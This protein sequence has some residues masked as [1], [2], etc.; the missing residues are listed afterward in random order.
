MNIAVSQSHLSQRVS[1]YV[2][3]V[4]SLSGEPLRVTLNKL[5]GAKSRKL[6]IGGLVRDL[7][8]GGI[9]NRH[10]DVD[11]VLNL[12]P[13]EVGQI[14]TRE[15]ATANRFGGYGTVKQGWKID[16]WA[17]S[18]TWAHT[19]GHA[20][21][22]YPV[23]IID[24]TFFN[25]DA[26][27]YDLDTQKVIMYENYLDELRARVLEIKL[28]PNPSVDGNAVRAVRR[29]KMWNYS[30]G[31]RLSSFLHKNVDRRMFKHIIETEQRI[32]GK[33]YAALY[34]SHHHLLE[35][36]TAPF[37]ECSNQLEFDL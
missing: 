9:G 31:P 20:E 16:F 6:I 3:T 4:T 37:N 30:C 36:L 8:R 26:V 13:D 15:H 24:T 21:L 10:F 34:D 19:E 27:A 23:D 2:N 25:V 28:E 22:H 32:Y 35:D 12:H 18:N 29:L 7:A 11:V 33:S 14:G 17:L 1:R 5:F